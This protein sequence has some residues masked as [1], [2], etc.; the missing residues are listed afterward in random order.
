MKAKTSS[1]TAADMEGFTVMPFN[2]ML[3]HDAL[4]HYTII[5]PDFV[6]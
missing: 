2:A 1:S 4:L 5:M 3:R 6:V